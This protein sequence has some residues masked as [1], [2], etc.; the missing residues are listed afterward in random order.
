MDTLTGLLGQIA[1]KNEGALAELYDRTS[2]FVYGL[3]LRITGDRPVAEDVTMEVYTEVWNGAGTFEAAQI[4]VAAWLV[5]MARNRAL[6]RVRE[7]RA[8]VRNA[9][10]QENREM[11]RHPQSVGR[12][13][14]E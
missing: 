12:F 8:L 1:S 7:A 2:R 9:E 4:T 3:A 11:F 14:S 6:N 13:L 5:T 10:G